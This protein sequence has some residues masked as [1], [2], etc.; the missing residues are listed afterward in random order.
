[1]KP[2]VRQQNILSRLRAL[3]RECSVDELAEGLQVSPLTVRR[4]LD[5]L[6][7]KGAIIRTLG[8][9]IA[10]GKIQNSV[11]QTRVATNF[12]LKQ[13][14]GRE[15]AREVKDGDVVIINDGST[16]FHLASCL[17]QCGRIT[18]YTNSIAMVGELSRFSNIRLYILGGEYHS[19]WF[20]IG[21]SLMERVLETIDANVVFVGTDALD[22]QGRCLVTD[23]DMARTTQM[24]LRRG[25][26]KVLLADATKLNASSHVIY[27]TLGDVDLWVTSKIPDRSALKRF[28]KLTEI[29][30]VKA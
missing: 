19:D 7:G 25:R 11:Y 5:K 12:D 20:Y 15:A 23:Q 13:A 27:G 16:A 29:R 30:E 28:Q 6:V 21:G 22:S 14:I 26:K 9:C 4:D 8:G 2:E 3:Q 17:G 24:M 10:T 18:V 1:M